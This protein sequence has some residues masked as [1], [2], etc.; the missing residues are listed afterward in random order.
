MITRAEIQRLAAQAG[1]RVEL[2]ERDYALGCFLLALARTSTLA[3]VL[4]FKGGTALRK[5]YFPAF[6]LSEDLDFT[7]LQPVSEDVMQKQV[8]EVCRRV[9]ADFGVP[10][11]IALWK[12]SR[13]LP[14]EEAYRARVSYIGPL[15]Q[16][17]T[18]PAR[19]TLDLTCYETV[20]LP[21]DPRP[22]IHSYSDAPTEPLA[23]RTYCL[24]EMLAEK[25]RALLRRSYPRDLYDV[26]Y[27]LSV[28]RA[29]LDQTRFQTIVTAKFQHKGYTLDSVA[30]LLRLARRPGM[31]VA[32]DRSIAHLA[33]E[34]HTY[35]EV[36]IA[37]EALLQE[38]L[39]L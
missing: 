3:E 26:W 4:A 23:V 8:N 25:L 27:L 32:W 19:I 29:Q 36:L 2:Q 6:R 17:G 22:V 1:V 37:L 38:W 39:R 9:T 16:P 21:A 18:D 24:E 33:P 7:L 30:S 5:I 34:P 12:Q 11:Q 15:G 13:D 31:D 14:G 28:Q 35:A 10:M 20:I